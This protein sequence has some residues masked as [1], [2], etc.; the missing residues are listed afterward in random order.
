MKAQVRENYWIPRLKTVLKKI[1]TRCEKCKIMAAEP[2]PKP[3]IGQLAPSRTTA[4]Y[5]FGVTGVDFVGPFQIKGDSEKAYVI[6]LGTSRAVYFATTKSLTTGE[7]ID[8]L[9]EFI[10]VHSRPK[11]IVSDNAST[12]KAAAEIIERLRKS[13]ELHDYLIEQDIKWEFI[14]KW[15]R[16]HGEDR[17]MKDYTEI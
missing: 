3:T 11:E 16:A 15:Q 12:F 1:K 9:N 2:F 13:E 4:I 10:S 6:N 5:P 8:K 7:F 14:H 17:F